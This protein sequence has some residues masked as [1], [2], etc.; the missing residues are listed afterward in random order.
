[1]NKVRKDNKIINDFL[2]NLPDTFG[3]LMIDDLEKLLKS[4]QQKITSKIRML[5]DFVVTVK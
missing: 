3:F 4:E 1:M 2:G 5:N